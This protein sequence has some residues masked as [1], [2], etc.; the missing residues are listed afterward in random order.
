MNL[1]E[2]RQAQARELQSLGNDPAPTDVD[3]ALA[4]LDALGPPP[5]ATWEGFIQL[6][7]WAKR[8]RKP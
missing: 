6:Q 4:R 2:F 8:P 5:D 7:E 3:A 1:A